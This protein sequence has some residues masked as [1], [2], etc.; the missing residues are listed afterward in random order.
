MR[1][2]P[3]EWAVLVNWGTA[4]GLVSGGL[5]AAQMWIVLKRSRCILQRWSLEAINNPNRIFFYRGNSDELAPMQGLLFE[6][7]GNNTF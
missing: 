3:V 5:C 1:L 2:S 4:L 7:Y 6:K